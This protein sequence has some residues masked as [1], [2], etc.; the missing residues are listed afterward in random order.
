MS[1]ELLSNGIA[2]MLFGMGVVF[3]FLA[4]LVIAIT[5]MSYTI[6]T[7]FPTASSPN[8]APPPPP[9]DDGLPPERILAAIK[10]AISEH[11]KH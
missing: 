7:Y 6:Q 9:D 4:V 3:T 1:N 5:V 2:L 11:R 10:L 8:P